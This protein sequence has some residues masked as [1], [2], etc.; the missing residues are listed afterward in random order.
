M[1]EYETCGYSFMPDIT[2]FVHAKLK[3]FNHV[4]VALASI[5]FYMNNSNAKDITRQTRLSRNSP[6]FYVF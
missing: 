1:D 5:C 4:N 2:V 6:Q 3:Y